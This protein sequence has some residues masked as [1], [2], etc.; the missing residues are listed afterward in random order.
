MNTTCNNYNIGKIPHAWYPSVNEDELLDYYRVKR[1][2]TEQDLA[3]RL[4]QYIADCALESITRDQFDSLAE[5]A[6]DTID[7][8]GYANFGDAL[9]DELERLNLMKR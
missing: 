4:N 7:E 8:F 9:H 3:T 6:D 1:M 5:W 2:L